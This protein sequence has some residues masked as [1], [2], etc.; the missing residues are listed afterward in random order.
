[1]ANKLRVFLKPTLDALNNVKISPI[2]PTQQILSPAGDPHRLTYHYHQRNDSTSSDT[3]IASTNDRDF[4][5]TTLFKG[6]L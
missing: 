5:E 4:Y 2:S 3:L 6:T 1:M